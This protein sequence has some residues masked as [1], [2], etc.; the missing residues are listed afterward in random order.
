MNDK[1]I[2]ITFDKEIDGPIKNDT[3]MKEKRIKK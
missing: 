2:K 3:G 1:S